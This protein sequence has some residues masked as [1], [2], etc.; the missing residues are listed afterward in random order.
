[1][2]PISMIAI[3]GAIRVIAHDAVHRITL[4]TQRAIARITLTDIGNT[5]NTDCAVMA[6]AADDVHD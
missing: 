6:D 3:V 2:R 1:M 4:I 5:D